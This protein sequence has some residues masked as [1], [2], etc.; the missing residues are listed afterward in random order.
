MLCCVNKHSNCCNRGYYARNRTNQ[1][2]KFTTTLHYRLPLLSQASWEIVEMQGQTHY[3]I[4]DN[5]E[6]RWCGVTTVMIRLMG[7]PG[8][9][10]L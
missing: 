3:I 2:D 4:Q 1:S 5:T 9:Q 7:F 10:Q 8:E 6:T